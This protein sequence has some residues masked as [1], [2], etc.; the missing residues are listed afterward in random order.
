MSRSTI[1]P[2]DGR[3]GPAEPVAPAEPVGSAARADPLY[4]PVLRPALR[5]LRR[6]RLTI[7]VGADPERAVA[8]SVRDPALIDLVCALDGRWTMSDLAVRHALSPDVVRQVVSELA[9][10]GI[11]RDAGTSRAPCC[12]AGHPGCAADHPASGGRARSR[13]RAVTETVRRLG[14]DLSAWDLL[15]GDGDQ[16]GDGGRREWSRRSC[17]RVGVVGS[18]RVALA[19]SV[20][21]GAAGIG[22]IDGGDDEPA[23]QSDRGVLALT[24]SDVGLGRREGLR[25]RLAETAPGSTLGGTG[26]PGRPDVVV[27]AGSG[28]PDRAVAVDLSRRGVPHLLITVGETLATVGPFVLPGTTAC[29]RC[30]DLRRADA[31]PAWPLVVDALAGGGPAGRE[32]DRA[33]AHP[34]C[35]DVL[36]T[37]AAAHAVLHLTAFLRGDRPPSA[38][39]TV[40]FRLP[41]GM[42]RRRS[43]RR[44]PDCG[45]GWGAAP[46]RLGDNGGCERAT[47]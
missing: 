32:R 4:R 10:A 43:W 3:P 36:T 15:D 38:D 47:P 42:P 14:P 19:V 35:D 30:L 29:V 45:C 34:A 6:D 26:E 33:A 37:V 25:R 17:A 23:R 7:Q 5:V 13:R 12:A 44:H 11:V 27:L 9:A 22:R 24:G 16:G 8:Y 31:D 21:L 39:A 40:E 41:S 2:A 46:R 28:A 20:L 18:G 1:H